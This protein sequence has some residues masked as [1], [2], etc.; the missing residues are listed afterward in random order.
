MCHLWLIVLTEIWVMV[1]P[2]HSSG[3]R[4]PVC[5]QE[6]EKPHLIWAKGAEGKVGPDYKTS[7]PRPTRL[8]F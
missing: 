2:G 3:S 1:E 6:A 8:Y 5:R 4:G 7:K